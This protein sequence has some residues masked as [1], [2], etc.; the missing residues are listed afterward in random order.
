MG[1][2]P[3]RRDYY[4]T[5][6]PETD[7]I[8]QGDIFWDVPSL[9]AGHPALVDRF[10]APLAKPV[11]TEPLRPPAFSKVRRGVVV[12]GDPVMVL[13]HTCD[14]YAPQKG[15]THH[16][17]LIGRIQRLYEAALSDPALARSGE[18]YN[19]TFFLPS[20]IDPSRDA[21][22]MVLNMRLMTTVD[23]AYL[24]PSRR[25]ARLSPAAL[26]ALRRRLAMFFSGYVPTL[27]EL[28]DA[29]LEGRA[30]RES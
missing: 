8:E 14:F 4:C 29:E 21:D 13:P 9:F 12:S 24:N 11:A 23:V 27:K 10:V 2:Y 25:L 26:I 28:L 16:F 3:R 18:G 20:W 22:D 19:H 1:W 17:R 6:L 7:E 5:D 15:R 30:P